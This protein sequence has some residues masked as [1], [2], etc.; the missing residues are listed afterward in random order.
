MGTG[1]Q[2]GIVWYLDVLVS[3]P[4][5]SSLN[6][7]C[8]GSACGFF[9]SKRAVW[10]FH[11]VPFRSRLQ[12]LPSLRLSLSYQ[13][14]SRQRRHARGCQAASVTGFCWFFSGEVLPVDVAWSAACNRVLVHELDHIV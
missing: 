9:E 12:G 13:D 14:L 5:P 10:G 1:V 2:L 3:D 6:L 7:D 11:G 4:C 8:R